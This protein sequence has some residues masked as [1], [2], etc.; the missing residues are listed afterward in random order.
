MSKRYLKT[1]LFSL[2]CAIGTVLLLYSSAD[3]TMLK[4]MFIPTGSLGVVL[5][6]ILAAMISV[7]L[8]THILMWRHVS[9]H[10]DL[11]AL[12]KR[13]Y[14]RLVFGTLYSAM[15]LGIWLVSVAIELPIAVFR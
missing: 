12:R 3:K 11:I 14:D 7:L 2:A 9:R 6:A 15:L 13:I 1:F 4:L 5:M 10:T 8:V